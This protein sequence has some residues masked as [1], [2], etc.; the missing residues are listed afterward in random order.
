[1]IV[2]NAILKI[3]LTDVVE[4]H[5][6]FFWNLLDKLLDLF[7]FVLVGFAV[8]HIVQV[9]IPWFV[10]AAVITVVLLTRFVVVFV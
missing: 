3:D 4:E 1:M 5:L 6:R 10:Y 9:S 8:W 7:V 2:G